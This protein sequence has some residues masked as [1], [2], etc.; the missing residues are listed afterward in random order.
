MIELI[1]NDPGQ[2]LRSYRV[3]LGGVEYIL[4][5]RYNQRLAR[6]FAELYSTDKEHAVEVSSDPFAS[7]R[8]RRPT[9]RV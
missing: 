5:L 2:P 6:Y 1:P 9:E 4:K 8:C 3:T 7:M